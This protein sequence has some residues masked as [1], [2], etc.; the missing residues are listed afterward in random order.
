[1]VTVPVVSGGNWMSE[2]AQ[3]PAAPAT[4]RFQSEEEE[5]EQVPIVTAEP[6]VV[7]TAMPKSKSAASRTKPPVQPAA[8]TK[9]VIEPEPAESSR[10]RFAELA[11]DPVYTPLPRDYAPDFTP[12]SRDS[13]LPKVEERVPAGAALFSGSGEESEADLEV[14][15]FLRKGQ[16]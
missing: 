4:L 2:P 3:T 1:V 9:S 11:E 15:A 6:A 8:E 5:E 7:A 14:P 10:P 16:F 12:G 13:S